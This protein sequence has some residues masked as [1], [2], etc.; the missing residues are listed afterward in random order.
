MC[1]RTKLVPI[2]E[3]LRGSY[4]DVFERGDY[5]PGREFDIDSEGRQCFA[6]DECIAPVIEVL[7]AYGVTTLGCC[8]GHGSG[9]G[10]ISVLTEQAQGADPLESARGYYRRL[11]EKRPEPFL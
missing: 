5:G 3:F 8:C 9:H 1:E 11:A 7:W 6:L 2:P 10:V 4:A